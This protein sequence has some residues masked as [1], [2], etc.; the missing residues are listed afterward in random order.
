MN[1]VD[2]EIKK[3]RRSQAIKKYYETH[4]EVCLERC[5][6]YYEKNKEKLQAKAK[7]RY[8]SKSKSCSHSE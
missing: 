5:R 3:Q 4:R 7:E 6:Q 2:P 1:Y 8:V